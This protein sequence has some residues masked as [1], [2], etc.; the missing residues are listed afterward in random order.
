MNKAEYKEAFRLASGPAELRDPTALNAGTFD[1]F[2]LSD[3]QPVTCTAAQLASL[4]SWQA[5]QFDGGWDA[6]KLTEIMVAGRRAFRV[7]G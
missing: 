4:I 7:I 6:E 5:R 3:F 1:G 2:G